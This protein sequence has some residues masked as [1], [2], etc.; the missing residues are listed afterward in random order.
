MT[1]ISGPFGPDLRGR[2]FAGARLDSV[3]LAGR[4]VRGADFTDADLRGADLSGIRAGMSRGWTALL[5]VGSLALSIGLGV[6]AGLCAQF[7]SAM[8][9]DDDTRRRLVVVFVVAALAAVLI[10]GI[11]KGLLF[12]TR[13]VLP[14]AAALAIAAAAI[15]ALSGI[16]TGAG[17]M[18]ALVFLALATVIVTLSVLVRATAGTAGGLYFA[19]V[20]IA[21][22][23]AGGAVGGGAIAA[24]VAIGAML[25][26]RRSARLEAAFPA[27]ARI[28]AAV[29]S[30][31]GTRFR[32]ADLA[33]AN[34]EHARLVACDFRGANL[35]GARL[36]HATVRLCRFDPAAPTGTPAAS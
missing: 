33:G 32:G 12:A 6:V 34:L 2:C 3:S 10:A 4:D 8:Y 14:V 24:A 16:G 31:G 15:G 19:I 30:R 20:A 11:W 7:L 9:V 25:M 23:L 17:G 21:G 28:T 27:L 5:V 29:A 26:A 36:D 1:T 13:H 22:G 35:R 18:L